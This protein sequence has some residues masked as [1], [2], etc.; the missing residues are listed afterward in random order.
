MATIKDVAKLAGVSISTASLAL[1]NQPHVREETRKKVLEA[2]KQLNY[3]PNGIARDLKSSKTYTIGLILADLAGP[4]Y[5]ELI[6]GI[7]DVTA[8]NGYDLV[9]LSAVGE[10]PKSVR[11]IQEK[12]TDGMIIMAH[13]IST[14]MIRK[15]A[16]P[17]FPIIVL[18]RKMEADHIYSVGVDNRKAAFEAV[19][20]LLKKGYRRI[21]YLGGPSNSTDNQQR[22]LGYRDALKA[23]GLKV[24]PKWCL[25]GRFVKEGGY[26]AVKLLAAQDL[27][28]EA[29][30]SA[31]DEM[32]IGAMEALEERGIKVPQEVAIVGFDDIQ[33]ARYVRPALTTVRQPM[34]DMGSMAASLLFRLFQKD[35]SVRSVMLETE[36]II[37]ESCGGNPSISGGDG[38]WNGGE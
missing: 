14:E 27:L 25:Q 7:Q 23:Q 9:A 31:N 36:L 17:D 16:R 21:G 4:F 13:N 20:Y 24:E 19:S 35:R 18:D 2:A 12:R 34:Y 30:F 37:R 33:L 22:F 8:S 1:N 38:K 32:A 11:Y 15:A 29:I 28:P 6:R 5:S 3:Q 26:Q 10:N